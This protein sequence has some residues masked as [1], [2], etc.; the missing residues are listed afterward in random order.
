MT[1]QFLEP[2]VPLD[3]AR[4]HSVSFVLPAYNEEGN[5]TRAIE[6]TVS[7]ARRHCHEFEVIVV[8]DGSN[9]RTATLVEECA[10][11][12]GPSASSGTAPTGAT[13]RRFARDF[14]RRR[15]ISSSTPTP[16]T[17]ST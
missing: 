9:D 2:A 8:D 3:R 10:A 1:S 17:S 14:P 13:E 6:S 7:V 5:I 16:T 11:V 12:T 15:A 4:R